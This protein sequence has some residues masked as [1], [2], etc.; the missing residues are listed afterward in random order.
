[1]HLL[2]PSSVAQKIV[3]LG[4]TKPGIVCSNLHRVANLGLKKGGQPRFTN[5]GSLP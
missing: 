1:M 3:N 2:C 5:L 4:S